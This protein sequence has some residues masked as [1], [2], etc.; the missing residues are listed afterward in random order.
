M[1]KGPM[2][3]AILSFQ[4]LPSFI[5]WDVPDLDKLLEE[6]RLLISAFKDHGIEASS[7]VWRDTKVDWTLFDVALIRST[8]DYIDHIESFLVVLNE[9]ETSPCTLFNP[10][11]VVHWNINKNYLR[12]LESWD[13]PTIPTYLASN[14]DLP[15]LQNEFDK[16]NWQM[17]VVKPTIGV[18]G[19]DT[20]RVA[21]NELDRIIEEL[22]IRQPGNEY[23]VQ[24]FIE[25]VVNEGEWSFIYFR[26]ELSHVLLKRPAPNDYR[27]HGLYG[28]TVEQATPPIGFIKQA[29]AILAK[30]PFDL[31]YARLDLIKVEDRLAVLEVELIEPIFYFNIVPDGVQR[32]VKATLAS[33][34]AVK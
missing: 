6:D 19:S 3:A 2:R 18:G 28:G 33:K 16:R 20:Y 27:A 17:A 13:V 29:E 24:P 14:I 8:W 25:S 5:T 9:I 26:G 21:T 34:G 32:L 10:E 15:A 31:L 4:D 1:E 30:I 7:I 11:E 23:L 12:D 22:K